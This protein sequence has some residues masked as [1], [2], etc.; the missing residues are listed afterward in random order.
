MNGFLWLGLISTGV[1][2][3]SLVFDGLGDAL[4]GFDALDAL[5]A[6]W[7]SLPVIAAFLGAF[8]FVTGALLDPL[9]LVALLVGAAAGV[10]FAFG[11]IRL[12]R[13]FRDMPTDPTETEAGLLAS[14]G[15]VVVA[16]VPGRYGEVLL[17]RPTGPVKVACTADAAIAAGTT[18]V[19]V[20][21]RSSTL[22]AVEPFDEGAS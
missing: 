4:D 3:V 21:V 19:V 5:H 8:G 16:P 7:L 17:Q 11:A 13:G 1:L 15:R 12:A 18:V 20:D 2:L 9:G 10:L 6:D 22:V 14:F